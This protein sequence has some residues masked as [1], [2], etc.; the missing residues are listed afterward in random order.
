MPNKPDT[1]GVRASDQAF[2]RIKL[3]SGSYGLTYER[4]LDLFSALF[5]EMFGDHIISKA[6]E[7]KPSARELLEIQRQTGL[8][9]SEKEPY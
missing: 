4:T 5:M 6:V 3:V 7:L 1:H 2:E 8:S 9:L